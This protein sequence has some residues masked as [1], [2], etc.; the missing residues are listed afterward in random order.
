FN[1]SGNVRGHMLLFRNPTGGV[2][3]AGRSSAVF[4]VTTSTNFTAP[5]SGYYGVVVLNDVGGGSGSFTIQVTRC[6][7]GVPLATNAPLT[8]PQ[9]KGYFQIN[10]TAT[11]FGALGLR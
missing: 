6:A 2:Y 9:P 3:W 10:P 1:P 11:Q 4:D 5:T 8:V 7:V